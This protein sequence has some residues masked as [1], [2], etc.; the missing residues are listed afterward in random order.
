MSN[1]FV[2][3][4]VKSQEI[5][6]NHITPDQGFGFGNVW[7]ILEDHEG[8]MWF[9]TEDGLIK[10]DGYSLVNFKHNSS[11]SSSISVN[12]I[13][14]L[15]EDSYNQIWVGTFGGGLNLYDRNTNSFRSYM[16][17]QDDP[18]SLPHNRVKS[19]IQDHQGLI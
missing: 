17:D 8:F 2:S 11:D 9:G 18:H 15:L 5:R 10:Y 19:L 7:A 1:T 16:F 3:N 13:T 6:F 12:F 4:E 14:T